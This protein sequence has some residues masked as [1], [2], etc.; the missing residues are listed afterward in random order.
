MSK[1]TEA[2]FSKTI[3]SLGLVLRTREKEGTGIIN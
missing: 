1:A 2:L 3:L